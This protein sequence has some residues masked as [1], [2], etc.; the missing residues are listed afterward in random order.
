MHIS[1]VSQQIGVG[2][3]KILIFFVFISSE[4][5]KHDIL[6]STFFKIRTLYA[7]FLVSIEQYT[8][9]SSGTY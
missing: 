5:L 7:R 2:S 4:N 6:K 9:Y 1:D 3:A 8:L